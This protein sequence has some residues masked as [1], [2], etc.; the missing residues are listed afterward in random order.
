MQWKFRFIRQNC[1]TNYA[2]CIFCAYTVRDQNYDT[3]LKNLVQHS[4]QIVLLLLGLG[5]L[6]YKID[7]LSLL[8]LYVESNSLPLYDVILSLIYFVLM[9]ISTKTTI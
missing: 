8:F 9:P 1:A 7:S 3:T 5:K 4:A 6:L 2:V